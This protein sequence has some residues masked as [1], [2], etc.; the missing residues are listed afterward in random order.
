MNDF[1]RTYCYCF[2]EVCEKKKGKKRRRRERSGT[3]QQ[4]GKGKSP[5]C[6][7]KIGKDVGN[8]IEDS[9]KFRSAE[10]IA[11]SH[12]LVDSDIVTPP[13]VVIRVIKSK[14]R[15]AVT[16]DTSFLSFMQGGGGRSTS[17]QV[18]AEPP[19]MCIIHGKHYLPHLENNFNSL[20]E[21][22]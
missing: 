22:L 6:E 7:E 20:P 17:Q 14:C 11:E 21:S 13:L 4:Q 10:K 16:I 3:D 18:K 15:I 5:R 1:T 19:L 2:T 8:E 9:S 12:D